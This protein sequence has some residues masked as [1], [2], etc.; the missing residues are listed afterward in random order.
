V[1]DFRRTFGHLAREVG[2]RV[3]ELIY[4]KAQ[5]TS[6]DRDSTHWNHVHLADEGGIFRGPSIVIHGTVHGSKDIDAQIQRVLDDAQKP[7]EDES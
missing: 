5:D 3:R 4:G 7:D 6:T 1:T 2:A